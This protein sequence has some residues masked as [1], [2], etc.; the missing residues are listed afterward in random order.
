[1]IEL[2]PVFRVP[3]TQ[4]FS[5]PPSISASQHSLQ[6]LW[7][8]DQVF[9][10]RLLQLFQNNL[11]QR[12]CRGGMNTVLQPESALDVTRTIITLGFLCHQHREESVLGRQFCFFLCPLSKEGVSSLHEMGRMQTLLVLWV[13]ELLLC[14]SASW[15]VL[16]AV[17]RFFA[18]QLLKT[19]INS[20][21]CF[22]LFSRF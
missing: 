2:P 6:W 3:E 17:G 9:A 15:G 8:L 18:S 13:Q 19:K 10:Q 5:P 12:K 21:V 20:L 1:M 4:T 7:A 14:P 22:N 16:R 11:C